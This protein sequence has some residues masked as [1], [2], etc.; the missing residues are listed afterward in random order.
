MDPNTER[1]VRKFQFLSLMALDPV[2]NGI[3]QRVGTL[4]IVDYWNR[5]TNTAWPSIATLVT[6]LQCS[7]TAVKTAIKK[8]EKQGFFFVHRGRGGVRSNRY[9]PNWTLVDKSQ[10]QTAIPSV[11]LPGHWSDQGGQLERP[12]AGNWSD[13][14]PREEPMDRNPFRERIASSSDDASCLQGLCCTL[15]QTFKDLQRLD[16][17]DL[18]FRQEWGLL[19]DAVQALEQKIGEGMDDLEVTGH[20]ERV[21]GDILSFEDA[22]WPRDPY[23]V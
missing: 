17:T 10:K 13:L 11:T 6:R 8:L 1:A 21:V 23:G 4:M 12:S 18:S 14:E 9:Q 20:F 2:L 22:T 15:E 19:M 16:P 7:R 5:Q 3:A